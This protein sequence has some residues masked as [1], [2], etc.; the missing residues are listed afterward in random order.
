MSERDS[1]QPGI[2]DHITNEEYHNG[3]GISRSGIMRFRKSPLH[4]WH[5][6]LSGIDTDEDE[7]PAKL[8]GKALHTLILEPEKVESLYIVGPKVDRR[9]KDGKSVW[10]A[11]LETVNGKEVITQDKFDH[12]QAIV[13]AINN[14]ATAR[15]LIIGAQYERSIYWHDSDSDLL[16]K[17]RPD[18]WQ[19]NF[20]GDLKTTADASDFHFQHDVNKYG[21]HIQ[22]AMIQEGIYATSK[23]IINDF[24]YIALEK[25]P[26]YAIGIYMLDK[27]AIEKGRDIFKSTLLRIKECFSKNEWPGYEIKK[28][29]LP[30]Y[31]FRE[32]NHV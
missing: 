8:F 2:Y 15:E 17:S 21:Y 26:P 28:I 32:E 19:P 4:F 10:N 12:I 20:I 23:K 6:Y 9:T 7:S 25:E 24:I 16:C 1:I 27:E 30:Y 3:D 22:A 5:A 31:A 11:F 13:K 29:S 14:H 18:I